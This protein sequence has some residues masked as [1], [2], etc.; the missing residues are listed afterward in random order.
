MSIL[1]VLLKPQVSIL[2]VGMDLKSQLT[3][4]KPGQ[5]LISPMDR[6]TLPMDPRTPQERPYRGSLVRLERRLSSMGKARAPG[7][8]GCLLGSNH[9]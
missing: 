6:S 9:L 5:T 7:F 3:K 4:E 8:S 2:S 1:P